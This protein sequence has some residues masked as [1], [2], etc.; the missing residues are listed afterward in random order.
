M[1]KYALMMLFGIFALASGPNAA[2][3]AQPTYEIGYTTTTPKG[4]I[5][6]TGTVV[7]LNATRPTGFVARVAGYR[8][9]NQ[10]S[11]SVWIGG[12]QVSTHTATAAALAVLGEKLVAGANV[13]FHLGYDAG[14]TG[15]PLTP[16]YCRAEDAAGSSA[17]V[18]SVAWFGY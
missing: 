1:K 9:Q 18:M 12:A 6:T 16:I 3:A 7:Q 5:C 13:T 8:I 10:S 2:E 14:R 15:L 17:A 4:V 11:S